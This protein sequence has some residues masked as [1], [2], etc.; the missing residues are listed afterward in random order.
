V[1]DTI[2][3]EPG[4]SAVQIVKVFVV[5]PDSRNLREHNREIVKPQ[6]FVDD[7]PQIFRQWVSRNA[8]VHFGRAI[9]VAA[10]TLYFWPIHRKASSVG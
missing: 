8:R 3:K 7:I 10:V 4:D 5:G 1:I 2:K 9:V 6:D